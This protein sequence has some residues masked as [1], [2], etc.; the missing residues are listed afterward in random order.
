MTRPGRTAAGPREGA[1]LGGTPGGA[2]LID[3]ICGRDAPSL[4][5]LAR[6]ADG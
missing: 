1:G 3:Q 6:P 5:S 2:E 4:P